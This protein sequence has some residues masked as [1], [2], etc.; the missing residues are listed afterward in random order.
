MKL[1][2]TF[3]LTCSVILAGVFDFET[4]SSDFKQTITNEE[5]SSIVY[6]GSFYASTQAK[7]LWIYKSPIDK[8][9][10][11]NKNRVVIIEPELE[12]VI[13]TNLQSAPNLTEILKSSKKVDN[14]TY[15]AVYNDIK[16]TIQVDNKLL[17]TI[18]YSDKLGNI[19]EIKLYN[20]SINTF[21]DDA[22]FQAVI[23]KDFD[24]V[25]Q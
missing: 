1:F 18:S 23:P 8:K 14:K 22:L 4:I 16:Y 21:L 11:F 6:E 5:N 13:I 10:Y 2:T 15:E 25:T 17:D 24:V 20:Q 3:L 12:Q 9:I 7:A 19:V